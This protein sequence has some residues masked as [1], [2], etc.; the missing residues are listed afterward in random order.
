MENKKH[1]PK[2]THKVD[3]WVLDTHKTCKVYVHTEI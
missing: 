3:M 1:E 2:N